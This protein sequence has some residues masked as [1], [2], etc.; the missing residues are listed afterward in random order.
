MD[1]YIESLK[2]LNEFRDM[3][4]VIY[5]MHGSFPVKCDL[6]D[7]LLEGAQLVKE[8]KAYSNPVNIFGNEVALYKF[9]YGGFLCD[10][11]KDPEETLT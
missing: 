7:K 9:P 1:R 5:P 8:G 6:I 10:L 2:H 4:D 3:F 11:K